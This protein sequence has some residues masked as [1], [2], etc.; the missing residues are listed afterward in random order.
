MDSRYP[1]THH[2]PTVHG[3]KLMDFLISEHSLREDQPE[4]FEHDQTREGAGYAASLLMHS[5]GQ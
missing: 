2:G 3:S 4:R 1:Y 5:A